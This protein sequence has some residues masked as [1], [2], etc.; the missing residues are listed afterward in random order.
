MSGA[1]VVIATNG[2][3]MAVRPVDSGAPVLTVAE[4]G[5]GMPIVISDL[6][7]PFVVEGMEEF[8]PASVFGASDDGVWFSSSDKTKMWQDS[9]MTVPVAADGDPVV[10]V[11]DKSGKGH[12]LTFANALYKV[13]AGG[14]GY[15][16]TDGATTLG[17]TGTV[18]MSG[19]DQVTVCVGIRK[20]SDAAAGTVVEL[21]L[22]NGRFSIGAPGS[23][24]AFAF[25]S[26][27]TSSGAATVSGAEWAAP[28]KAIVTGIGDISADMSVLR[29]N[30]VQRSS[31][32]SDQGTGN[33]SNAALGI[34]AK[35]DG[36]GK[37]ALDIYEVFV[38]GRHLSAGDL[39]SLEDYVGTNMGV[40]RAALSTTYMLPD[41]ALAANPT[42]G[43]T[44]TGMT[45][46]PD[47][48]WWIANDGR[49][50]EGDVTYTPGFVHLSADFGEVINEL[51]MSAA[52]A[53]PQ[54]IQGLVYD[55]T[56]NT[57]WFAD[58]LNSLVRHCDLT[59]A[60]IGSPINPGVQPN[61]LAYSSGADELY[62][63]TD[64]DAT[65]LI[66]SAATGA[67]LRSIE[68]PIADIDMMQFVGGN[69]WLTTGANGANGS[70]V[71]CRASDGVE[72]KRYASLE[73]AQAIEGV[74]VSGS[75]MWI[76]NDGKFH[77][78]ADPP[79]SA[80]LKY[81]LIG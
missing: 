48:T 42:G 10:K 31:S 32:A 25:A 44:C 49:T 39:A 71:V 63:S 60:L 51:N 9:G 56:D 73:N 33:L 76:A 67:F 7:A 50:T 78:N 43:F 53:T 14:L 69:L 16:E 62:I 15:I 24:T 20:R 66:H 77:I 6:G 12:V 2:Y 57:L 17:S 5:F 1:P 68:A 40:P 75:S 8:T 30:R 27:G 80:V 21:G 74:Y 19:T 70:V 37:A 72:I 79:I 58:K 65:I 3:G 22:A 41:S 55:V 38:I 45:R 81:N 34:G 59:G 64:S 47:G 36:N 13:D 23:T 28:V 26:R 4:N 61:G 52:Y 54:S 18:N 11:Q 29:V 35:L 46:A